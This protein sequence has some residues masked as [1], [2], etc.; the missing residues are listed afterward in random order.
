MYFI[1]VTNY[2][3]IIAMTSSVNTIIYTEFNPKDLKFTNLEENE[4]TNGQLIGYPRY[5]ING[6]EVNLQ[7]QLPWI[8]IFTFGVPPINQF[9]KTEGD[10]SHLKIPLDLSDPEVNELANKLKELDH[11]YSSPETIEKLFGKKGKKYK[12]VSIYK[13]DQATE[14]DSD[15]DTVDKKKINKP[16]PPSFKLRLKL[17]YPDKKIESHVFE[18]EKDPD[19]KKTTRTKVDVSTVDEFSNYIKKDSRVRCIVKPFKIWAHPLTKKDPEFGIL[20]RLEKVEVDKLSINKSTDNSDNF[21][22]SDDEEIP[23]VSNL[24]L[25][26]DSSD[27]SDDDSSV[28]EEVIEKK[29]IAEVD[30]DSD[31]DSDEETVKQVETSSKKVI[32]TVDSDDSDEE[33]VITKAPVKTKKNVK[34]KK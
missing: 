30:S 27:N 8:K 24:K 19:T 32:Q 31:S 6:S 10:R 22:D 11:I 12:F 9:Y 2:F 25:K 1:Y 13:E 21:I 28:E 23:K 20:F 17:S 15:D 3:F 26:E 7:I 18:S 33:V 4:K 5:T 16:R 29:K 14:Y 34:S